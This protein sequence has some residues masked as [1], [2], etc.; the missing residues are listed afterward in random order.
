[1]EVVYFTGH[2]GTSS[3]NAKKIRKSDFRF[4]SGWFGTGAYFFD[5]DKE[6]ARNWAISK[7]S[8]KRVEVI[9]CNI[10]V[11]KSKLLDLCNPK[12]ENSKNFHFFRSEFLKKA[13]N[14]ANIVESKESLDCK[15]IDYLIKKDNLEVIRNTSYTYTD[16]ERKSNKLGSNIANAFEICVANLECIK[17]KR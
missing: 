16:E 11:T 4:K 13:E 7:H 10:E 8:G 15:I 6:M 12:S 14:L 1:M 2:H 5:D 17:S 3:E 9:E